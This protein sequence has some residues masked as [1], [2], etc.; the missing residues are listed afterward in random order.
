MNLVFSSHFIL[1]MVGGGN[2]NT[3]T[4]SRYGFVLNVILFARLPV[5]H[6]EFNRSAPSSARARCRQTHQRERAVGSAPAGG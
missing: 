1:W 2:I 3:A 6:L 4:V 5:H